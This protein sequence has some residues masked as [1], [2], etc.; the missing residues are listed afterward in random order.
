MTSELVREMFGSVVATLFDPLPIRFKAADEQGVGPVRRACGTTAIGSI[1][2]R[3]SV[4]RN[5]FLC[6]C[7]DFIDGES[8][9]SGGKLG[10]NTPLSSG[11]EVWI[12]PA[13]SGGSG[14]A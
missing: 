1:P 14:Q 11:A 5:A 4:N 12:L 6:G 7:L 10:L 9:R 13:V 3:T 2:L 8:V